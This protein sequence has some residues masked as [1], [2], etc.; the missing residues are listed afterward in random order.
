MNGA[1]EKL[2][3]W[4]RLERGISLADLRLPINAGRIDLRGLS[5]P[6][7]TVLR[8]WQTSLANV[9]EIQP[10]G[11]FRNVKLENLDFSGSEL[12]AT[13]FME[14]VINNCCFDNCDL[15]GLRLC[16]TTFTDCSFRS[17]N[18]RDA[19]LGAATVSGPFAGKRN[20]FVRVDFSRSDIRGTV[21]VAAA[22]EG[23][24]FRN[25]KLVKM[26]FGTSTFADCRFE[27]ELREVIF[28]DSDM[29]ARG[30]AEDAFP[31]NEMKDVDFSRTRLL[32]VEFRRLSLDRVLLPNDAE[33][34]VINDFG[35]VL[36]RVIAA[37][38]VQGDETARLLLAY[39]NV[40]R[41]WAPPI[42][43]GVLNLQ[44]LSAAGEDAPERIASLVRQLSGETN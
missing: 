33:H 22:F 18:L 21:Y 9:S 35:N 41:R 39:L 14:C 40:T 7:P 3:S 16:A 20:S 32:D 25:A 36:D 42:G 5:F 1:A 15:Q 44:S 31:Y 37:L 12:R 19:G 38:R 4:R 10:N 11:I 27:G 24:L 28:W 23:C 17:A 30:F 29:F 13:H 43:R 34:I 2:E 8:K 26:S 6:E